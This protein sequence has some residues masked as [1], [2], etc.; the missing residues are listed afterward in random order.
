MNLYLPSSSFKPG[1]DVTVAWGQQGPRPPV[2]NPEPVALNAL[3]PSIDGM[4]STGS[5]ERGCGHR[6]QQWHDV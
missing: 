2:L 4:V 5:V 1:A 3:P 6:S